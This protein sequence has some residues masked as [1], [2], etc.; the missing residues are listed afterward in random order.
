M[1]KF[2]EALSEVIAEFCV[3][4][5]KEWKEEEHPRNKLGQFANKE[6]VDL[7]NIE[8]NEI[9]QSEK[10]KKLDD[11]LKGAIDF[12]YTTEPVKSL[13]GQ[14]FQRDGVKLTDKVTEYYSKFYPNGVNNP[15]LGNVRL[16]KEGVKDSLGHKIW[17]EKAA[18][19]MAVPEVIEKGYV[20][21]EQKNWKNRG[22]D[23]AVLVAPIKIGKD[24]YICEVVI[25]IGKARKG[26]YLHRVEIS[27]ELAEV[28]KTANGSTPTSSKLI[29]A[30]KI[31][32]FKY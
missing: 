1:N 6:D 26:L 29:I 32:D 15:K 5:G 3:E 4:N 7:I 8:Y 22:Y 21:D 27:K 18:A 16:D 24:D 2:Y 25:K 19:F 28:F 14:E 11:N 9:I 20:F 17:S 30:Q 12:I 31:E 13:T 23:T 10:Y